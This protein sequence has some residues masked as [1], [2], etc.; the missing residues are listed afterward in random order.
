M[1]VCKSHKFKSYWLFAL[2]ETI[3]AQHYVKEV[4]YSSTSTSNKHRL[5][6]ALTLNNKILNYHTNQMRA[7]LELSNRK[8]HIMLQVK[9][10]RQ[11]EHNF[12]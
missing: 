2:K 9:G 4:Q 11:G 6:N 8:S 5:Y 12:H 10:K 3:D 7:Y 1:G